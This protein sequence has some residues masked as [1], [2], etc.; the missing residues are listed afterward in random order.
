MAAWRSCKTIAHELNLALEGREDAARSVLTQI[1]TLMTQL[2][3]NKADIVNAIDSLNGLAVSVHKQ[4]RHH[5]RRARA[6]CPSALTSLDK[7]RA[8]LVKMLQALDRLSDVGVRVIQASKD[9]HD[10]LAPPARPGAHRARRT[11]A[12]TSSSPSTSS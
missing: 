7:Q 10:R 11:P 3:D 6:S 4:E 8:D 2:D 9:V 12:T 5:R 1:G